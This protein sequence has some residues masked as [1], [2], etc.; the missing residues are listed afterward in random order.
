MKG[1]YRGDFYKA[2]AFVTHILVI[3]IFHY[4]G[5]FKLAKSYRFQDLGQHG[6]GLFKK[7]I[8]INV[9]ALTS[10]YGMLLVKG[11]VSAVQ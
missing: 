10:D 3:D 9:K 6:S 5:A 7:K 1:Y 4:R 11:R 2:S 8:F